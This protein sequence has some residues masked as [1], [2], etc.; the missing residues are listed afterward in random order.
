MQ[1]HA[2]ELN[3]R[4]RCAIFEHIGSISPAML[5]CS[6]CSSLGS[7]AGATG[8]VIIRCQSWWHNARPPLP[9]IVTSQRAGH[10]Y[11]PPPSRWTT[12]CLSVR[13]QSYWSLVYWQAH[14][15]GR[16]GSKNVP[17]FKV[18]LIR[19]CAITRNVDSNSCPG[20]NCAE[21]LSVKVTSCR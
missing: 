13:D 8:V 1:M 18:L 9:P 15:A 17:R 10:W 7:W 14:V 4:G 3:H 2:V 6:F 5:F 12:V 11:L 21:S 16:A 20:T 19:C